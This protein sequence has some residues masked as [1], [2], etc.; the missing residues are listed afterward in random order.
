MIVVVDSTPLIYLGAIGRFDLLRS[1]YGRILIPSAV[2]DEVVNQGEGR[3]GAQET[4]AADWVDVKSVS[5][6]TLAAALADHLDGGEREV[7]ALA[8]ELRAKMVIMD[9]TAGRR[10]LDARAIPYVGTIGALMQ[11]KLRGLLA[12]LRPELEQLRK[13]GFHV[14]DRICEACLRSVSE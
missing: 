11:A 5:D 2:F 7:I 3:W 12:E 13:C 14:S 10:E 6:P 8:T 9:E 4:A 1:L